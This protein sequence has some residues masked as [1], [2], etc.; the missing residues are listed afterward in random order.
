[1]P[2]NVLKDRVLGGIGSTAL[3][4]TAAVAWATLIKSLPEGCADALSNWV[5]WGPSVLLAV[6]GASIRGAKNP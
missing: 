2:K 3:G 5:V 6:W 1:M 4:S